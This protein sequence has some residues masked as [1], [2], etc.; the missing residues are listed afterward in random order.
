M[1]EKEEMK[2]P[3]QRNE[4]EKAQGEERNEEGG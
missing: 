2:A 3:K 4:E 1:K